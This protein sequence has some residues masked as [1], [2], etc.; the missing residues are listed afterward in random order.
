MIADHGIAEK[1]RTRV[2]G[3]QRLDQPHDPFDLRHVAEVTGE[4]C[5]DFAE[6]SR[7][8]EVGKESPEFCRLW[9]DPRCRPWPGCHESSTVGTDQTGK[10]S[11]SNAKTEARP[12]TPPRAT[13]LFTTMTAGFAML[14]SPF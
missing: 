2:A 8:G 5:A 14:R 4:D 6:P 10:P 7:G 1:E 9:D 13:R 12:P 11:L 3:F